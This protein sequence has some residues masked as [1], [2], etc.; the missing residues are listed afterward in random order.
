MP[1]S[2]RV[3]HESVPKVKSSLLRNGFPSQK[4]LSENL[5]VAQ[6]T[7]SNF[8]NG[9]PVDFANFVEICRVLGQEWRDIADLEGNPHPDPPQD[10]ITCILIADRCPHPSLAGQL[11]QALS[12]AGHQV[13][14]APALTATHLQQCDYL[15]LL[16]SEQSAGS[17]MLLE[18]V[19]AAKELRDTAPQKP[20]ILPI[21]L[22]LP[23]ALP[24]SFDLHRLLEGV[25]PWEW[26]SAWD[27]STLVGG[28]GSSPLLSLIKES[29]TSLPA[30]H[31][32]AVRW[33]DITGSKNRAWQNEKS[34]FNFPPLPAATPELPE[35]QVELASRFYIERPPIESRCYDT[36]IQPGALIRIKASRQ[37]GKTSL[38]A[39]ILH[40]AEQLGSRTVAVN[41]QLANQRI[42]HSSDTFLQ[43]F[44][45]SIS[46]ELGM[47]DSEQLAK[48]AQLADLIGSNQSCKAYFEQYLLPNL[49]APLTLGLDEVDRVFES[50]EIADDFFGLLR[51][52]HEEAKRREIWKNLRLI[53]VH[54]TEVYIPLD[55]NKSPFNVGLPVELPEFT[56]EQVR[57]L[58]KR[59]GLDWNAGEAEQL[60]ALVGGHPY[61]VRLAMY[62]IARQEMGLNRLV[63]EAAT[64]A[65]LYSDHL[66][67]HLWNLEKYPQ[68]K[69]AMREVVT[70]A[71]AVRLPAERAFKLNSMGLVKLQGNDCTPRCDLYCQY[72]RERLGCR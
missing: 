11:Q 20:A 57:E 54:S 46:L 13:R 60:V 22:D 59:H 31:K 25:Q 29:R 6:S 33:S 38:L 12:A 8:L 4:I 10:V 15:L 35:G 9:K 19:R 39:R 68:I 1:R 43:W 70:A 24:L 67:R 72:F 5:G 34:V 47:L 66:R 42:F 37:M 26:R 30:D 7:V 62:A 16:L 50:P 18:E 53:V 27:I 21:C 69:S 40:R 32:F 23:W 28:N 49:P 71:G 56:I 48:Y 55:V 51:S 52:L 44:C 41:F 61:L 63:R 65:G 58:A 17:E 2:L 45:A 14:T 36:I 3:R 64:E